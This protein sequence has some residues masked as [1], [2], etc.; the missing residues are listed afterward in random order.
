[1]SAPSRQAVKSSLSKHY[2]DVRITIINSLED[3]HALVNRNPDLVFQGMKYIPKPSKPGLQRKERI[4]ISQFLDA[5]GIASTGSQHRAHQNELRKDLA[6]DAVEEAGLNTSKYSIIYANQDE[7]RLSNELSY[8]LFVKPL[9][10]GGSEGIDSDSVVFNYP[11]LRKKVLHI[12]STLNEDVLIE[13]YLPGQEYSVAVMKKSDTNQMHVMPIAITPPIS[14][15]NTSFL[16]HQ[17]KSQDL[18]SFG[19]VSDPFIHKQLSDFALSIFETLG[20]RDY[21]RIDIRYDKQGMPSFIEANL[22]PSIL[23][24]YGNFPKACKLN[25]DMDYEDTI[26]NIV[27]LG[28]NRNKTYTPAPT[29]IAKPLLSTTSVT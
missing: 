29:F 15:N 18:E 11:E 16:S 7:I 4:W 12:K 8:P 13:E 2:S 19:K 25:I 26:L 10:L 21:G 23:K 22:I 28:L 14:T 27:Q 24:D 5:N 9:S 20:A 3:L 17:I 6:K 1:M